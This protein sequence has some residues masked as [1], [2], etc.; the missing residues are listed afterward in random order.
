MPTTEYKHVRFE[1]ESP[2]FYRAYDLENGYLGIV[3]DTMF[4]YS[5]EENLK[6][7]EAAT[8]EELSEITHFMS[9]LQRKDG[10]K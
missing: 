1:R 9:Q 7:V 4:D 8:F 10:D 2:N 6:N 5:W 3:S